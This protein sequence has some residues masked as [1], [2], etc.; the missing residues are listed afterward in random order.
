MQLVTDE[1]FQNHY[2]PM[3]DPRDPAPDLSECL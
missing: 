1:Q 2:V 3:K